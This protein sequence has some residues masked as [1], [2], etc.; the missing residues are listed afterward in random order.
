MP[1]VT[2]S[3]NP[4]S[5]NASTYGTTYGTLSGQLPH[6]AAARTY[7]RQLFL[8][9]LFCLVAGGLALLFDLPVASWFAGRPLPKAIA[10]ALD[11]SEI[12]GSAI[13]VAMLMVAVVALDASLRR[14]RFNDLLRM[15]AV[16]ITGGLLADLGKLLFT[17]VRPHTLDFAAL[18]QDALGMDAAGAKARAA[19]SIGW[20]VFAR[21]LDTFGTAAAA[22][23][24]MAAADWAWRKPAALMSFPSGHAAVA[25]GFAAALGWKYPAGRWVF[26]LFAVLAAVQRLSSSSHYPS[27]VAVGAGLA[28]VAA[29]LW[30]SEPA[31]S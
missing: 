31:G 13:G 4:H 27:D 6:H 10:K 25:A 17:R 3:R 11:L 5:S 16:I 29:S 26:F 30:L 24:A 22:D 20:G 12:F 1:I 7:R 21:V 14:P 23:P 15:V 19:D 28:L 9:G 2:T 8:G 18:G